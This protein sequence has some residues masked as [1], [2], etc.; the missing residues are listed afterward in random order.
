LALQFR[1]NYII[2]GGIVLNEPNITEMPLF[3]ENLIF[4]NLSGNKL[5]DFIEIQLGSV[6]EKEQRAA[7]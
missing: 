2:S 7:V 1:K 6:L 5:R 4:G 3:F